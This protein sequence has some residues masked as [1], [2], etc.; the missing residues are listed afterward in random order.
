M[1]RAN[2]FQKA[3]RL[4]FQTGETTQLD[5]ANSTLAE[6]VQ[7][8]DLG[9]WEAFPV[10]LATAAEAGGF[11]YEA[12]NACL[13]EGE[14]KYLKLLI[15]VSL[16]LY[17]GLGLEFSWR[18]QLFGN[19]PARLIASFSAKLELDA[20]LE[21]GALILQ[22]GKLKENMRLKPRQ[23]SENPAKPDVKQRK[24]ALLESALLRIFTTR[25]KGLLLKRLNRE[26]MTKTEK[27]YF[28][29]VIKKK[30]QALANEDLHR[31]ARRVL[32]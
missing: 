19:F 13:E 6:V 28:S 11:S 16:G 20:P 5:D 26:N 12:A 17:D 3:V 23:I 21:L 9:L 2:L 7:S 30:A 29:R 31:L 10:M 18:K 25:Q 14:R 27:E 8:H 22:P 15:F 32:E 24:A 4:G 1:D